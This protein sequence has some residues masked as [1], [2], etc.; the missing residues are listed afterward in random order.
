MEN[1]KINQEKITN[2]DIKKVSWRWIMGSQITWNYEK[3]MAPGYLYA[4]LPV[5]RKLYTKEDELKEMLHNHLQ[6]FNTTPHMG[7][8]ILGIDIATEESEGIKGKEAVNGI[9][10][11]LMGPFAGVGDDH[12]GR[13]DWNNLWFHRCLHGH[14]RQSYRRRAV[15]DCTGASYG[16]PLLYGRLKL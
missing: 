14:K 13:F 7:G 9:K 16:W 1:L 5:L 2:E 6:F 10:T 3:M 12:C 8:F 11:G 4:M 15:D